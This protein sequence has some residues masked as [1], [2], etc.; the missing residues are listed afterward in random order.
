MIISGDEAP[1]EFSIREGE[2]YI[3]CDHPIVDGKLVDSISAQMKWLKVNQRVLEPRLTII[4]DS[5]RGDKD[6]ALIIEIYFGSS[7]GEIK[8]LQKA[9]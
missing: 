6:R 9:K 2:N 5:L 1:I 8:V 3:N 7:S 4:A